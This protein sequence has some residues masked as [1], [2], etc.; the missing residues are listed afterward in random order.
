MKEFVTVI[1]G[2]ISWFLIAFFAVFLTGL[3]WR[4]AW[5]II[6]NIMGVVG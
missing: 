4:L 5:M 2:F 6:N 3:A 1:V